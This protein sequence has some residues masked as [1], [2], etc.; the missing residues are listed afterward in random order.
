MLPGGKPAALP[1]PRR[2]LPA[3]ALTATFSVAAAIGPT[4]V[5]SLY[6]KDGA[7]AGLPEVSAPPA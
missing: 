7:S 6:G 1:S 3:A 4:S 5:A 2:A